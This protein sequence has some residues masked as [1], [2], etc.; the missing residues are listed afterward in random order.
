MGVTIGG[1]P[2]Q[3]HLDAVNGAKAYALMLNFAQRRIDLTLEDVLE[4]HRTVVGNDNPI[5]GEISQERVSI[6]GS[7]HVPPN[8]TKVPR[9]LDEMV[10]RCHADPVAGAHP[11]DVAS[12]LHFDLLTI[13][14]FKD[15]NGR[16]S[17]LLQ[18]LHLI[19]EGYAPILIDPQ[20]KARYFDVLNASQTE[21]PGVGNPRP[22]QAYMAELE[23][24]ALDRY[25]RILHQQNDRTTQD[26]VDWNERKN[27]GRKR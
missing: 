11:V 20:Q 8:Y 27:G 26:V 2:L 13:H 9:L 15:G 10:E 18:N 23:R 3:D 19:R 16:T 14:P 25:A 24:E 7:H 4:L 6:R 17:R 21:V 1:K 12:R 5:A 22:F